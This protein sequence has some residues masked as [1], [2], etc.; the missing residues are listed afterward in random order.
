MYYFYYI[1]GPV[2]RDEPDNIKRLW[3]R[4]LLTD[5]EK[6]GNQSGNSSSSLK[7]T[8]ASLIPNGPD[9]ADE[10][11]WYVP[12]SYSFTTARFNMAKEI[13]IVST[14]RD[15][16]ALV[17]HLV[18][19]TLLTYIAISTLGRFS[20]GC[21]PRKSS[22]TNHIVAPKTYE[23]NSG[24]FISFMDSMN[25]FI[26]SQRLTEVQKCDALRSRLNNEANSFID[27]SMLSSRMKG[28]GSY[29][30]LCALIMTY[31]GASVSTDMIES[32]ISFGNRSQNESEN[33]YAYFAVINRLGH[34]AYPQFRQ[35]ERDDL[36]ARRFMRGLNDDYL[37]KTMINDYKSDHPDSNVL[38]LAIK[39]GNILE[40]KRVGVNMVIV[41]CPCVAQNQRLGAVNI[42][43][44]C[45]LCKPAVTITPTK[46]QQRKALV[47]TQ[48]LDE[49]RYCY[50]CHL[51]GHLKR[52]C[53]VGANDERA[54]LCEEGL[55]NSQ[56]STVDQMRTLKGTC[57][58]D[59][60]YCEFLA[61]TG[62]ERT[63]IHESM[64]PADKRHLIIPTLMT[65]M[66]ADGSV[67]PV[68]GEY[69]CGI[70]LGDSVTMCDVLITK[71]LNSNCLLG[72]DFLTQCP[73]TRA[74]LEALY[75]AVNA[76]LQQVTLKTEKVQ[77]DE[78]K[79]VGCFRAQVLS[80]NEYH[81]LR[82]DN[83]LILVAPC[84]PLKSSCAE[85]QTKCTKED[86]E[87]KTEQDEFRFPAADLPKRAYHDVF[88][89]VDGPVKSEPTLV[90]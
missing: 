43:V 78:G 50:H 47:G 88:H 37:R 77:T 3:N 83:S 38:K 68:L 67:T 74:P 87:E 41:N 20:L 24:S 29:K 70:T 85:T 65:I 76:S 12:R 23:K 2:L 22:D 79:T 45:S 14:V 80:P 60:V 7:S 9:M 11:P 34:D 59:N 21:K 71:N 89:T 86:W 84:P 61:D 57:K 33:V 90:D 4:V 26:G 5:L 15:A 46:Y 82:R 30:D 53:P 31:Y 63:I 55:D 36:I 73:L 58:I 81:T 18:I 8:L 40:T 1:I 69:R 72:M 49:K 19:S 6:P 48:G 27:N 28:S 39:H 32:L 16:F 17:I 42:R 54:S 51:P 35:S 25:R 75:T 52:N 44:R 13:F 10:V 64:I 62:A 66:I 56:A